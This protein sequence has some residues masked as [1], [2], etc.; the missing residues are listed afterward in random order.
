MKEES[1]KIFFLAG[2]IGIFL[3]FL[4][5][6]QIPFSLFPYDL[7]LISLTGLFLTARFHLKGCSYALILLAIVGLLFHLFFEDHHMA[8]L[9]LEAALCS[10]FIVAAL[11]FEEDAKS[12]H[13]LQSQ[14]TSFQATIKNLEEDSLR[15]REAFVSDQIASHEKINDLQKSLE[16]IQSDKNSLEMLND[17]LRKSN[18]KY[19]EEQK[20]FEERLFSEKEKLGKVLIDLEESRKQIKDSREEEHLH[21]LLEEEKLKRQESEKKE[22]ALQEAL[23][24]NEEKIHELI[25]IDFLYKQLR[26]QF[27]E[28]TQILHETR[29]VLFKM[30]TEIQKLR[31]EKEEALLELGSFFDGA[32]ERFEQE[33]GVLQEENA[34]LQELITLLTSE[35]S[36]AS[37]FATYRTPL[38]AG[39]A[40]L[41]ETLRETLLP[42]KKKRAKKAPQQDLLF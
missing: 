25:R 9:L 33:I 19:F 34:R 32:I 2:P 28:K 11:V 42:I 15:A 39:Q 12:F 36:Q 40:S 5:A 6:M 13:Q 38:P 18:A 16:E 17:V 1:T 29:T 22:R 21:L 7:A 23:F 26:E 37:S 35:I 31:M 10:S 30:E 3:A 24:Q 4:L 41:E 14:L 27:E 20:A 8:R